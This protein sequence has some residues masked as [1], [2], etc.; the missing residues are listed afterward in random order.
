MTAPPGEPERP[1]LGLRLLAVAAAVL[2]ALWWLAGLSRHFWA[3]QSPSPSHP[4]GVR[5]K[6][7]QVFYFSGPVGIFMAHYLWVFFPILGI[8]LAWELMARI[9]A[10]PRE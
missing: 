4:Y 5:F 7:G 9:R 6:G 8:V 2:F 3:P 1:P 10:R